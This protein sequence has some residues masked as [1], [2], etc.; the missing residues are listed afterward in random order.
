[1]NTWRILTGDSAT[2]LREL[3]EAAADC[4]VTSPPYWGL[5]DYQMDEQLGLEPTPDEYVTRMVEVFREVRRVLRDDGTLWLNIGDSYAGGG[6]GARD[7]ERWPKQSRN[8]H[9]PTHAKKTWLTGGAKTEEVAIR[10]RNVGSAAGCKPKDLI[11]VPW[12]LA[13]AL[14]ADGW[15]LRSD[16][17]WN[18]ANPMPESV[19]DRPTKAHEYL[20]LLAKSERY[21]YDAQSIAEEEST[22]SAARYGYEFGGRKNRA[23]TK[24]E[25]DG[26]G[27]RTHPIGERISDGKRNKRSVWTI[28]TQPF[29]EAH[30][31]TFPPKLVEPCVL[32]GS[33]I[34]GTVLDPFAG[35]GTTGQVALANGR[36][37]IG[38]ELNP[39][40]VAM[41]ERR[42]GGT[43]L[44]AR[45]AP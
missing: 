17:I 15:W 18:K 2:A 11:G 14:R 35:S 10:S 45:A 1:M 16:I 5:R 27:T 30:F 42:L 9:M 6:C 26:P 44:F 34:G 7:A 4:C 33:R 28:P 21:Y 22:A 37:F 41:A 29:P 32:A 24:A 31:A 40:Y 23:L 12:L 36:S 20:F 39:E 43:A 8:D 3:P 38:I 19:T 25:A 13:F